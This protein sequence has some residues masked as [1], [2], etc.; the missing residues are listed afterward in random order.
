MADIVLTTLNARYSH[1]ALGLRYL[2][3]NLGELQAR[4]AIQEFT[5][6]QRPHDIA[7]H[8]LAANPRIIGLGLYIWNARETAELAAILKQ[9]RPDIYLVA[10]GPEASHEW[11]QQPIAAWVD[12]VIQGPGD[13]TFARLCRALLAGEAPAGA[14][15]AG[16]TPDLRQ[17]ALPY[18]FYS[19]HDIAH[20]VIY[21]EASRG[22][23]FRCA[24]CLSALDKTAVA[25]DL[26]AVLAE[27]DQLWQRGARR[28]K[29]VDRTFN[30]NPA[31]CAQL[32]D[33]FL[34]RIDGQTFLHFEVVPD[35]LPEALKSRLQ[36]FPPGSLQLEIG[37]QTFNPEVQ[38]RIQRVQH[39]VRAQENLRF[40]REQTHAHL[41]TDLIFGLPG[42]TLASIANSF[43]Q[44]VALNPHE[45]Q[46]GILKRL[47]GAPINALSATF[48]MRYSP[49]PPYALL[50][51]ATLDFALMQRLTR[52]ARYWDVIANS[53]RFRHTLPLLLGTQDPFSRWLALSDWLYA[54]IGQT[55][56]IALERWFDWLYQ[57]GQ[58]VLALPPV[59]LQAA[60]QADFLASGVK[61]NPAFL[62]A[63]AHAP[64]VARHTTLPR[65]ARHT[66]VSDA[67]T[68]VDGG[69]V[70]DVAVGSSKS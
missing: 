59:V 17:L 10:G 16:E 33:F 67:Q 9:L 49:F 40:L 20:R 44:L 28:F 22:C 69:A 63:R 51:S 18:R 3:A 14:V 57:G 39:N 6:A 35:R 2:F 56:H 32:L 58:A 43:N 4:A 21:V 62:T 23:P 26:A 68:Q 47:R 5:I 27:L 30:L 11:A 8:I 19:D 15:L 66:V 70:L 60:L 53:G 48:A 13:W 42:E 61:K 41:H 31:W 36:Q 29:F 64:A 34:A 12:Y 65:Q 46:L 1:T 7:E 50:A 52:L 55:H 54:A 37:V 25:F 24:F 38:A 45:I